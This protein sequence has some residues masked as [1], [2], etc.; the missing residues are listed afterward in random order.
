MTHREHLDRAT[1]GARDRERPARKRSRG[2]GSVARRILTSFVLLLVAFSLPTSWS[3]YAQR[4][5][6]QE[7]TLVRTGYAPL[8]LSLG[9]AL[10]TQ[11]LV[12]AQL[13]HI[14]DAKNP[15]D[16]RGWIE[17]Q[18]KLRPLS[19]TGVRA[20]A[21]RALRQNE[22]ERAQRLGEEISSEVS[23]I[24]RFLSTDGD[25]L[26]Q[27][28]SALERGE[29]ARAEEQRAALIDQQIEGARRLRELMRRVERAM[30]E[31]GNEAASRERRAIELLVI[32]TVVTLAMGIATA[33]Y[34][35]RVLAPLARVTDR[36]EAVARGDLTPREI[37]AASDEIGE[38]AATF[39]AMVSAIGRARSELV[40]AER[41]AAVGRMAAHVTHEIRNPISALG[42]NVELLEE[43]L[44]GLPEAGEARQLIGAIHGEVDRLAALS[45]QY[46]SLARKPTPDLTPGELGEL[47]SM[48][49]R[50]VRPELDRAS[51]SLSVELDPALPEVRFDEA[52][53]RQALL[54]LIRNAREAMPQGGRLWLRAAQAGDGVVLYIDD[55]GQGI[56]ESA[57]ASL[58]DPF[59]TTKKQGTGLGLAVTKEIV[60]AHGG[61]I[62]C[63]PRDGGGTRFSVWLP[64][65]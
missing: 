8:L 54:N 61:R 11:N 15:A 49:A 17:T 36:A 20:A 21:D 23:D 35:R 3:I 9:T 34:A 38:L 58:F 16:A 19:F 59:F 24:E 42:L 33:L 63:S 47:L 25:G 60:E 50:F 43:E 44:E 12:S 48:T 32:L 37:P 6:A 65:A 14:T 40:A 31:L 28:F 13:N 18:R 64:A 26:A 1:L 56:P 62:E 53:M 41:L 7:A 46:L 5:A 10:E 2:A 27:L 51:V 52:Q 45:G 57:H 22:D 55:T 29:R 39:E 30:D 4:R